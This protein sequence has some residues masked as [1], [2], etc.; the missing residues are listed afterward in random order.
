[1][2]GFQCFQGSLWKASTITG[3]NWDSLRIGSRV[4]C[5]PKMVYEALT[6][7]WGRKG[8]ALGSHRLNLP[9]AMAAVLGGDVGLVWCGVWGWGTGVRGWR[10]VG[11]G[12]VSRGMKVMGRWLLSSPWL[13][14]GS[15]FWYNSLQMATFVQC[16]NIC[17][18]GLCPHFKCS[19]GIQNWTDD[20]YW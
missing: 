3:S 18:R 9:L 8:T 11:E 10:W 7:E 17:G 15:M 14:K 16:V 5:P 6:K 4:F 13:Y 19:E 2:S 12:W 20:Y 1:M